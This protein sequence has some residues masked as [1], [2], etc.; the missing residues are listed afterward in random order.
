MS[1][2]EGEEIRM[3]GIPAKKGL[4]GQQSGHRA[5]YQEEGSDYWR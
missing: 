3:S 4:H 5:G 1:L 2:N